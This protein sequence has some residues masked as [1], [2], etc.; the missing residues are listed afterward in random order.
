MGNIHSNDNYL[1]TIRFIS[2]ST[3]LV[4]KEYLEKINH[5]PNH[6]DAEPLEARGPMQSHWLHRFKAGPIHK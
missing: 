5:L 4:R 1:L 3:I 2:R 6:H